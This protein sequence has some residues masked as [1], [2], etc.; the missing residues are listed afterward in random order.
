MA[1]VTCAA[2]CKH[3]DLHHQ[4]CLR[5]SITIEYTS[6]DLDWPCRHFEPIQVT[7]KEFGRCLLATT[8]RNNSPSA[9]R[10]NVVGRLQPSTA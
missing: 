7:S 1:R 4:L 6:N 10:S 8:E 9:F 3:A 2:A 5:D